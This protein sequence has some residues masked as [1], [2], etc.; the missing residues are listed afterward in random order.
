MAE[1]HHIQ[2][3]YRTILDVLAGE[4]IGHEAQLLDLEKTIGEANAEAAKL[5]V[6]ADNQFQ[7]CCSLFVIGFS[8]SIGGERGGQTGQG[9]GPDRTSGPFL[10]SLSFVIGISH[11]TRGGNNLISFELKQHYEETLVASTRETD[12]LLSDYKS[13]VALFLKFLSSHVNRP[14]VIPLSLKAPN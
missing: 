3:Q 6:S 12:R 11:Q 14:A 2:R 7:F 4:R 9:R 8:V 13:V 10:I 5:K 1:A